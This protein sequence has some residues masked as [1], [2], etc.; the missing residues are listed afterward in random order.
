MFELIAM[1]CVD[2]I[3]SFVTLLHCFAFFFFSLFFSVREGYV[4]TGAKKNKNGRVEEM[5]SLKPDGLLRE[6]SKS[7]SP[8]RR[9]VQVTVH[10]VAGV[11]R[12]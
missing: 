11:R 12:F 10:I 4:D 2:E 8:V 1:S 6:T 7:Q 3:M 5:R 9:E